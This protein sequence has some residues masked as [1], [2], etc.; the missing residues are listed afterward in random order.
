[1]DA[2]FVTSALRTAAKISSLRQTSRAE[3]PIDRL[4]TDLTEMI[5]RKI[6]LLFHECV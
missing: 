5:R 3:A 4:E 2:I 6:K 1:L